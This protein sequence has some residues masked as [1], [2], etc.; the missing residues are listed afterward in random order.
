MDRDLVDSFLLVCAAR[1]LDRVLRVVDLRRLIRGVDHRRLHALRG[2]L[3][4]KQEVGADT[5]H[6]ARLDMVVLNG[7][8]LEYD[9]GDVD[10]VRVE[11]RAG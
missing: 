10:G 11:L 2:K 6:P 9:T 1:T 4:V 7:L 8:V 5:V 3:E